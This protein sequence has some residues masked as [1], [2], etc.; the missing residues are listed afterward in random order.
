MS[1]ILDLNKDAPLLDLAKAAP[2]LRTL[3]ARLTWSMHPVH[4]ASLTDGFDLDIFSF[5][6]NTS[7]KISGGQDVVFFN[8]KVYANGAIT[9]PQDNRTGGEETCAY[10]LAS[11]PADRSFVDIYVCVYEAQKRGQHFGMMAGARLA[12]EDAETDSLLQAY[13]IAEYAGKAVL[14]AGRLAKTAAGWTFQPIGE[15]AMADPNSVAR[16]YM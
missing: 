11:I 4:G 7:E 10:K 15:A 5:V 8:N 13:N 1:N 16:A 9:L 6:L 12:L 2:T 3:R 14:H